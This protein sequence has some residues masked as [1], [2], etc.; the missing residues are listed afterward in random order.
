MDNHY[1]DLIESGNG[2]KVIEFFKE[3]KDSPTLFENGHPFE[4]IDIIPENYKYER[5]WDEL[6]RI[7]FPDH[8][9]LM[10]ISD[11]IKQ[12]RLKDNFWI[13]YPVMNE[14]KLLRDEDVVTLTFHKKHSGL[15]FVQCPSVGSSFSS[16]K[17]FLVCLYEN[18]TL[19]DIV[20]GIRRKLGYL[21]LANGF[22]GHDCGDGYGGIL[23]WDF[24]C[25]RNYSIFDG[26]AIACPESGGS[27][28][29]EL[30]K[31]GDIGMFIDYINYMMDLG[32]PQEQWNERDNQI[33]YLQNCNGEDMPETLE[34]KNYYDI[35]DYFDETL[36]L[37]DNFDPEMIV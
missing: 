14:Y 6:L 24:G 7:D 13:K 25:H 30:P 26:N 15:F 23:S 8:Y 2:N 1:N 22:Y 27:P 4:K 5:F 9:Y 36:A 19:I 17:K 18:I 11:P 3:H 28:F 12:D 21:G 16:E 29:G 37:F 20:K 33:I 31:R 10:W 35:K 34:K 32:I